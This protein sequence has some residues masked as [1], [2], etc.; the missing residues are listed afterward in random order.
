MSDSFSDE[1]AKAI[2]ARAIELDSRTQITSRDDLRQIALDLDISPDSLEAALREHATALGTHRNVAAK[3]AA[4][5]IAGVGIPLGFAAGSLF[6][7]SF[8]LVSLGLMGVGLVA[9]GGLVILEGAAGTL[10]SFHVKNLALWAGVAGGAAL[11]AVLL[12]AGGP[13][14]PI[15]IAAGWGFRSW[16][17]SSILGSAA[18]IAVRRAMRLHTGGPGNA[19]SERLET[20]GGRRARLARRVLGW[21]TPTLRRGRAKGDPSIPLFHAASL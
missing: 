4:T 17:A 13:T 7:V 1:Q 9:S 3:R 5:A 11:S 10:R 12:G 8:G 6:P 19:L 15:L 18:V 14:A 2:L 16:V 21:F 20:G